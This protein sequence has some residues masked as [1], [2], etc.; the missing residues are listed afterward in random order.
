[1]KTLT[2]KGIQAIYDEALEQ[3]NTVMARACKTQL[4]KITM[5]EK[6]HKTIVSKFKKG[7]IISV[8]IGGKSFRTLND[9]LK[10]HENHN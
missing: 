5:E 1:M 2:K 7:E 4:D 8:A 6:R 3:N 9:Y 10:Y